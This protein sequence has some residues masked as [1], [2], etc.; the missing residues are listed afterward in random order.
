MSGF[1]GDRLAEQRASLAPVFSMRTHEGV[2]RRIPGNLAHDVRDQASGRVIVFVHGLCETDRYWG[3]GATKRY[4]DPTVTFGSMLRDSDGWTPLYAE[5]NSGLH[6]SANGRLLADY[7]D[8]LTRAWPVPVREVALVGHSMGG[9]VVRSAAHLGAEAEHG[10][11]AALTHVIGLGAPNTGAPLE[12]L[13]NRGTHA[14]A[15]LPETRPFA[16]WLNRRSV[17]IKDL[18]HGALLEHDW[19]GID[20]ED[21][22]DRCTPATLLAGVQYSMVS[23]TLSREPDGFLAHDLLVQH[24]SAHGSGPKRRIEFDIDRLYPRRPADPLRPAHRPDVYARSSAG[25]KAARTSSCFRLRSG[26]DQIAIREIEQLKYRYL[27]AL[28][29]KEWD[30]FG[31]TLAEDID[32][33]YGTRLDFSGRDQ[34]VELHA[35]VAAGH[36]HHPAPVPP[37]GDR[38]RRGQRRRHLV[39]GGQGAGHRA[40]AHAHRCVAS[41]PTPTSAATAAGRSRRRAT[42]APSR[43][44]SH[45]RPT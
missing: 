12:R 5:Y 7:L 39:P 43:R 16:D 23:A 24:V 42:S 32:A 40:A 11:A 20:P 6:I 31:Q 44:W 38:R 8:E 2:L 35:R 37:P 41:T 25:S 15:R 28:D 4:G 13:V 21:R 34:V 45:C 29:L 9:L 19:F 33:T 22:L 1:W 36:D 10:W 3:Y 30:E 27:R 17:G 18:R 26:M 14:M